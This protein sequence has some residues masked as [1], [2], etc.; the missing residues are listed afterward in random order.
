MQLDGSQS[1]KDLHRVV[2]DSV[3]VEPAVIRRTKCTSYMCKAHGTFHGHT[4][5]LNHT[6]T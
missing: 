2:P 6:S 1:D 3:V 4:N 5:A